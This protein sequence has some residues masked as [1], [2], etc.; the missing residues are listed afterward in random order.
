MRESKNKV[1]IKSPLVGEYALK[2]LKSF[3]H[4]TPNEIHHELLNRS[5]LM[6]LVSYFEVLVADL[7]HALFRI[8]PDAALTE[9]KSLGVKELKKFSSIDEALRS[10]IS[11]AV[12][13]LLRGSVND[14]HKFF[15][16]R[17]KID[18]KLL[19]PDWAQWNEYFQ[20]RHIMVHA[21]GRVTERYLSNVD[22]EKL[23]PHIPKPSLGDR[24]GIED[25]YLERTINAFEVSGLLLCQEVWR[26][27]VP[28]DGERRFGPLRGLLDVVYSRLLSRHWYV[29]ERLATWGEQDGEASEDHM[30]VCKF[31]RWLTVKRQGRWTEVEEEVKAFDCSA[32]NRK[33]I[34]ARAS[35]L[36]QAEEFFELL[37]KALGADDISIEALKE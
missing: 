22:W 15:Q 33:Y 7:A 2:L 17:M 26:K 3:F 23:A 29:A 37:P 30:L 21:G 5:T 4:Y 25:A 19:T 6:S 32:K 31:N 36:E 16:T 10:I 14:W 8:A 35:L 27:L 1:E 18:M 13:D 24:L 34:L 12:D 28:G 20:R 11:D 9:D